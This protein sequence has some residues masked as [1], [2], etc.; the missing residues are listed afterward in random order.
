MA[1]RNGS[2]M[3]TAFRVGC[4]GP[5]VLRDVRDN[6]TI[7]ISLLQRR[8]LAAPALRAEMYADSEWLIDAL[9]DGDP[10]RST[11]ASRRQLSPA[12]ARTLASASFGR[13]SSGRYEVIV[14]AK[15]AN[16]RTIGRWKSPQVR[17]GRISL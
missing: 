14:L 9:W 15:N 4:L 13:L 12:H 11:R 8:L 6:R 5:T 16:G 7:P 3:V 1:K 17:I 2:G 10:P